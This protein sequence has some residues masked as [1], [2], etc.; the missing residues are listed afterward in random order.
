VQRRLSA[1]AFASFQRRAPAA[2]WR[3]GGGAGR[4]PP[5]L[6]EFETNTEL[7]DRF[8]QRVMLRHGI[9]DDV[10]FAAD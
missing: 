2:L 7:D 10:R 4:T 1:S 9:P 3:G 8:A 6:R 5:Y